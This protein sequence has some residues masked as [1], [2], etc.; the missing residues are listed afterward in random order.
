MLIHLEGKLQMIGNRDDDEEME[1]LH[2][3]HQHW[4][5]KIESQRLFALDICNHDGIKLTGRLIRAFRGR[6]CDLNLD[7][8]G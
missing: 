7:D 6:Y 3:G 8:Q 5:A 4:I 2:T 1:I